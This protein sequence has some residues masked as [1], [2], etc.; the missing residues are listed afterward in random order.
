MTQP[1]P[2]SFLSRQAISSA[3]HERDGPLPPRDL[4]LQREGTLGA[5][6]QGRSARTADAHTY[7]ARPTGPGDDAQADLACPETARQGD[8]R[9]DTDHRGARARAARTAALSLRPG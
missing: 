4:A 7:A 9:L 2:H 8:W 1:R 5:R 3:R 6:L